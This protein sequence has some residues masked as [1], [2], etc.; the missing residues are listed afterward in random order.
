MRTER[1]AKNIAMS[2]VSQIIIILLGFISR[3]VFINSLGAE[4]LGVNGLLTNVLS[5]MVLI[6][7]GIGISIVYNL[8]KPL[9]EGDEEKIIALVQLY[10]KAYGVLAMIMLGMSCVL[11]LFLGKLMKTDQPISGMFLVYSIFVIKNM[12]SYL[13]AY[14]WALI[15][16]DQKG[17]ILSRNNLF[18]QIITTVIKIAVLK[19]T[20]SYLMFLVAELIIFIGQNIFNT[21]VVYK[22]YPYIKTKENRVIDQDTKKNINQNVRAMFLHNIGGYLVTSTDNILISALVSLKSLGLYSNYTM[23]IGQLSALLGPIIGGIGAGVGNLIATEDRKKVYSIFKISFFVSFWI[24]SFAAIFLFNLLEPFIEWWIGEGYL[25]DRLTFLVI[26]LN[27][28]IGGMRG[29]IGTFKSKAGLFVQDKYAPVIEGVLNL[30]ASIILVRYIGLVG[31]FIGTT[32][33][34]LAVPFWNQ[35]RIVY[36]E[37]FKQPVRKF[38]YKYMI[39][40]ILMLVSGFITTVI[41]NTCVSGN[42]FISLVMRGMICVLVP[43]AIYLGLFFRTKEFEYLWNAIKGQTLRLRIKNRNVVELEREG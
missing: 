37:L 33:S 10:K 5:M 3:K 23:V 25:L 16:A 35:A 43:N 41:C 31:V 2:I 21:Y 4:Y 7:S 6:E 15:N 36:R 8:Y 13:N 24:Y 38:F 22:H 32:I 39:Y 1:A 42:S 19:I 28:Y 40:T 12:V 17:Y 34:T 18:F 29:P 14:K 27:F 11:Y 30:V 20:D 9:A 26:L